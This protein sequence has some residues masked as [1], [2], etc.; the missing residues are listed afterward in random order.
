MTQMPP[1]GP[2]GPVTYQTPPP[3]AQANQGMA[4]ASLICGIL[5]LVTFCGWYL[6]VPLGVVAIVL[7]QMAKGKVARGEGGGGGLAKAGVICGAIGVALS[8]LITILAVVGFSLFG[9]RMKAEIERQQ[10][11]Q[12]QQ[13]QGTSQQLVVPMPVSSL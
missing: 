8:V 5:S 11:I 12:Q 4:I 9:S 13:K 2:T 7:G 3:N 6:S 1:P 10:R